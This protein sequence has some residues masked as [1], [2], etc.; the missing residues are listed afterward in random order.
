MKGSTLEE[1]VIIGENTNIGENSIIS[2][3]A[4]GNN[5]KLGPNVSVRHSIIHDNVVIGSN[6]QVKGCIIGENA[7]IGANVVIYE[8]SIIGPG[9]HIKEDCKPIGP[10]TWIVAEKP[11]D[12]FDDATDIKD[13]VASDFGPKAFLFIQQNDDE[14]SDS[15]E[16]DCDENSPAATLEDA[17]GHIVLSEDDRD[18]ETSSISTEGSDDFP[19]VDDGAQDLIND[20]DAKFRQFHEE[21]FDSLFRGFEENTEEA[22]L[23]LEVNASRHA[24]NVTATQVVRSVI[25]NVF[26]IAGITA[27]KIDLTPTTLIAEA[28][29]KLTFFKKLIQ[30]YVKNEQ[31]EQDC[32]RAIEMYCWENPAFLHAAPKVIHF[33]YDVMEILPE[34]IILTWF[35]NVE[36][37]DEELANSEN[38]LR[39]KLQS[40][41]EWLEESEDE[42]DDD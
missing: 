3:A 10:L 8:K 28:K 6:C 15:E 16:E 37:D 41:V 39:K 12:E 31:S 22:N 14:N 38:D 21:V 4:L 13:S 19:L 40:F 7:V 32:M 17:W 35:Y 27:S 23:A 11:F 25:M 34:E 42:S 24:Y 2:N 5:C 36:D 33:M 20:S 29:Q 1:G 18:D 26:A 9:V 30:R